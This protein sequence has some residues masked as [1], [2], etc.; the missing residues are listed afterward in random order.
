[1]ITARTA[2]FADIET[3]VELMRRFYAESG[4]PLDREEAARGF[5]DL[6]SDPSRGAV[7]I[8]SVDG[9]AAG[10]IVLSV[11]F[12]MEFGGI[13]ASI[14]DL[15]VLPA[16]R[17]RGVARAGL[18]ALLAECT[19]RGCRSLHVQVAPNDV[20]ARTLYAA[21]GL[22]PRTDDRL[23]LEMR[24]PGRAEGPRLRASSTGSESTRL[25][26]A[27]PADSVLLSNL[28]ELYI[29]DL[30]AAF[31]HVTMGADGRF[32][33]AQ[34]PL[35]WSD[36]ER[37]FAYLIQHDSQTAGFALATRGSPASEDPEVYDVAEFFVLRQL[38]RSG[39]GRRAA[40]LLWQDLP[41]KW[42]VRVSEANSTGFAFWRRAVAEFTKSDVSPSIR[43]GRV[44]SW[45]VFE[46]DSSI[47]Q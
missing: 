29:H 46:L 32:G 43:P 16:Y 33:Y 1:M 40:R 36:R 28:L 14:D 38:R 12:A 20:A 13:S 44:A 15:Y 27:T 9:E 30:S 21:F 47:A 17:R 24:L 5:A 31:P 37:R 23:E 11:R 7:W 3:L 39:V 25:V 4:F 10:H 22:A 26:T 8:L 6:I 19:R 42:V 34:L 45:L 18:Q 35:Y 2:S 41:G